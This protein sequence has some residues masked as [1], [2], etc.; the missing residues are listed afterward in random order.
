MDQPLS[1]ALTVEPF[2][3]LPWLPS[4]TT[5]F[6]GAASF[7]RL[8]LR[9]DARHT[10]RRSEAKP[11]GVAMPPLTNADELL[12]TR[13]H[14]ERLIVRARSARPEQNAAAP[15]TANARGGSQER[16]RNRS[17]QRRTLRG[18]SIQG[19]SRVATFVPIGRIGCFLWLLSLQQQ[20]K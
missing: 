2:L 19:V 3:A 7:I 4:R 14:P 8:A 1:V 13:L 10:G 15:N 6:I 17:A 11:S 20:R 18:C 9:A 16:A 12:R 5:D